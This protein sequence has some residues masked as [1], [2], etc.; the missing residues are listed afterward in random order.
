MMVPTVVY[1]NSPKVQALFAEDPMPPHVAKIAREVDLSWDVAVRASRLL[2]VPA[3]TVE[4]LQLVRYLSPDAEYKLHHDHGGFYGTTTEN[5]PWT[6]LVFLNSV[7]EGGHTAFPKLDLEIVPR[8]GDA[9][10]WS[11]VKKNNQDDGGGWI[12]DEDMMHAGKPP[13]KGQK[14]AMNIW[15]GFE[16]AQQRV[17]EAG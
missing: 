5:R 14:Y 7:E 13:A 11:N 15:F 17:G 10:I 6:M 9:L 8:F 4:P 3:D 2:G 12:V 1:R 16:S